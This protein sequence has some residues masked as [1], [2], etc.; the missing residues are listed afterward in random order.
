MDALPNEDHLARP[1]AEGRFQWVRRGWPEL[2]LAIA[3]FVLYAPS[4]SRGVTFS[5]GPEISTAIVTLGVIH[6]TGYPIFTVLGHLFTRLPLPV[7]ACVKIELLNALLAVGAALF[8]ARAVRRLVLFSGE[9]D[10]GVDELGLARWA[11]L[12]AGLTLGVCP[13]LW[14]QV[15]IPEV[16]AFHVFL[17]S[18]AV[19]HLVGFEV[20]GDSR[21]LLRAALPM[22]VGLA[23]HVT[24]VYLVGATAVYVLIRRPS[25]YWIWVSAPVRRLRSRAGGAPICPSPG[26]WHFPAGCVLGALPLLSYGY[27]LWATEHTS[28]IAWGGVHDWESLWAHVSGAQYRRFMQGLDFPDLWVRLATLPTALT[29]QFLAVGAGLSAIGALVMARRAVRLFVG[30]LL[31]ALANI[32]HGLQYSVADY[33]NYYL[34][35]A[36]ITAVA[37]GVGLWWAVE[38]LRRLAGDRSRW[39]FALVVA[40][41]LSLSA[42]AVALSSLWGAPPVATTLTAVGGR[43]VALALVLAA[44]IAAVV[45]FVLRSR[46]AGSAVTRRVRVSHVALALVTAGYVTVGVARSARL[47]DERVIGGP[48]ARDVVAAVPAGAIYMTMGDGFIFSQWY[49]QHV[50]GLGMDFG[51]V[52][53][54]GLDH[55]WYREGYLPPHY[56]S[57]C[58]PIWGAYAGDARG[59][60]SA[61]ATFDGRMSL[62]SARAWIKIG[63]GRFRGDRRRHGE[64]QALLRT[65]ALDAGSTLR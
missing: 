55:A 37:V 29:Q 11:G 60:S 3:L 45:G 6:P 26:W 1:G 12:V 21:Q 18:W 61:C 15:R 5:D 42:G 14:H 7:E 4:L 48:H 33:V 2:A 54:W 35:V 63:E 56:P 53:I 25:F 43:A 27:L 50:L 57:E 20:E 41:L 19:Y 16:Y 59:Y 30:L 44:V 24:M 47:V 10:A 62:E 39:V 46:A 32:G 8:V 65:R 64:G 34:P 49:Y 40:G 22:G 31:A 52:Y 17:T 38:L 51:V 9:R 13:L 58:D 36:V 23:H 28:G